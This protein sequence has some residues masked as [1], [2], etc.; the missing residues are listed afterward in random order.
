MQTIFLVIYMM[1]GNIVAEALPV[2]DSLAQCNKRV[3]EI[4]QNPPHASELPD[5]I[6]LIYVGCVQSNAGRAAK[7]AD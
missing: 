6:D 4:L 1:F 3:Q 5:G 7:H 2:K